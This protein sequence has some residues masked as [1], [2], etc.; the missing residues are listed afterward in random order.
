M[1]VGGQVTGRRAVRGVLFFLL[2][3]L[4]LGGLLGA[5]Y[6]GVAGYAGLP[7]LITEF[8]RVFVTLGVGAWIA[9]TGVRETDPDRSQEG[10]I[11]EDATLRA[12]PR[13]AALYLGAAALLIVPL[14]GFDATFALGY[15]LASAAVG[16]PAVVMLLRMG[17][18]H[19]RSSRRLLGRCQRCGY[20]L[21]GGFEECSECGDPNLWRQQA[22]RRAEWASTA[23]T[24]PTYREE[25]SGAATAAPTRHL[26][27]RPA[28]L[29]TRRQRRIALYGLSL[30]VAVAALA[31]WLF[32]IVL[33]PE[34]SRS[35][36]DPN[37]R[38]PYHRG[39]M[40]VLPC[41]VIVGIAAFRVWRLRHIDPDIATSPAALWPVSPPALLC[42]NASDRFWRMY[43][44]VV[45]A[46]VACLTVGVVL[47]MQSGAGRLGAFLGATTI[48]ILLGAIPPRERRKALAWRRTFDRCEACVQSFRNSTSN[49]CSRCGQHNAWRGSSSNR[50]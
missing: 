17:R 37:I 24:P 39:H 47:R 28:L 19:I 23:E 1:S 36:R 33:G 32:L 11:V 41:I 13:G 49:V 10:R 20:D 15:L 40:V 2:L 27:P 4:P 16:V 5:I 43:P 34:L 7:P 46:V 8:A 38:R 29:D 44:W 25:P 50:R 48:G 12:S 22:R 18:Q 9:R 35:F 6:G 21:A 30:S 45:A 26:A 42:L 14:L 31:A 3:G